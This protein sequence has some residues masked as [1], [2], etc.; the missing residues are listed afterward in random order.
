MKKVYL[1]LPP[2]VKSNGF[3]EKLREVV[4][5]NDNEIEITNEMHGITTAVVE[6]SEAGVKL[7]EA[8]GFIV[9]P[10]DV[11]FIAHEATRVY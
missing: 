10:N 5:S 4:E 3:F 6:S 8:S 9:T 7:L 2:T 11:K 1:V